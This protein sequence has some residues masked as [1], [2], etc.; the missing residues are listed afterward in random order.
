MALARPLASANRAASIPEG[1]SG[2]LPNS[3][4]ITPVVKAT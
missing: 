3:D 1:M 2:A 4:R